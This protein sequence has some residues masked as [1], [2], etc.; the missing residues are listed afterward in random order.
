MNVDFWINK[1]KTNDPFQIADDMNIIVLHEN[2]GTINGYY[3]KAY[4]QKFIHINENL[5]EHM[6]EF[7]C[8][9]EL[10]HAILHPKS[11]TPFLTEKTLL[12]VDKLEIEANDFAVNLLIPNQDLEEYK[13][14]TVG[15]LATIY[16]YSEALI[17]LRLKG[18]MY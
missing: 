1:Y 11:R 12:S 7:T 3:V 5:P 16:G 8:A 6:K 13:N 17:N 9:H 15:Q 14:Y 2:L 18:V 4:R 10:G